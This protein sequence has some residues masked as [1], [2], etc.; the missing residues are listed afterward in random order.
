MLYYKDNSLVVSLYTTF[1]WYDELPNDSM[2]TFAELETL[3]VKRFAGATKKVTIIDLT[4]EK[5][6]RIKVSPSTLRGGEI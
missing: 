5:G 1:E 3:F 6:E 4:L 2:K